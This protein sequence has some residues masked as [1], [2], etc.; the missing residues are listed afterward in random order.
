MNSV[1]YLSMA[2]HPLLNCSMI[3]PTGQINI[4]DLTFNVAPTIGV[5]DRCII[6]EFHM[7][8]KLLRLALVALINN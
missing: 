1:L 7:S 6:K 2:I 4:L 5:I 8:R 3:K